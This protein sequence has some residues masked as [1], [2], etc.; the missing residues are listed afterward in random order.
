MNF[1]NKKSI[2]KQAPGHYHMKWIRPRTAQR[3]DDDFLYST[4]KTCLF[5]QIFTAWGCQFGGSGFFDFS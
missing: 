3:C 4:Q 2:W 1:R 5:E